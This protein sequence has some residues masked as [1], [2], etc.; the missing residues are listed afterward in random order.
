MDCTDGWLFDYT[1]HIT[2]VV[3]NGKITSIS[4]ER[5]TDRSDAPEMNETFLK[6]A[7]SGRKMSNSA[8]RL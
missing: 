6:Y 2:M 4:V 7:V 3:K 8:N 5:T 1:L